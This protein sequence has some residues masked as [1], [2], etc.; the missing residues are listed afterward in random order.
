M[1]TTD[2]QRPTDLTHWR[3]QMAISL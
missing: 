2:D 1:L 3:F